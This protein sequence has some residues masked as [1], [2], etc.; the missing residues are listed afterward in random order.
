MSEVVDRDLTLKVLR[1]MYPLRLPSKKT[2][3]TKPP[4]LAKIY[5]LDNGK[6]EKLDQSNLAESNLVLVG[7]IQLFSLG[8]KDTKRI[9]LELGSSNKAFVKAYIPDIALVKCKK[10]NAILEKSSMK[11]EILK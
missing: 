6:K 9:S 11:A 8:S 1:G 10:A 5:F 2:L 4:E 7:L 3:K